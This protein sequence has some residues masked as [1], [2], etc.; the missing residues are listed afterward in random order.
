MSI[1]SVLFFPIFIVLTI[2]FSLV[3][4]LA[5]LVDPGGNRAH[6]VGCRLGHVS[7]FFLRGTGSDHLPG[8]LSPC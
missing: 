4:I 3:A 6:R 7:P 2:G 8:T 1:T 5:A